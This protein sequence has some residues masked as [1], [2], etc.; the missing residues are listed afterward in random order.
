MTHLQSTYYS[1][2]CLCFYWVCRAVSPLLA[3]GDRVFKLFFWVLI[4]E[5]VAYAL[6]P[7]AIAA[8]RSW[9]FTLFRIMS[10]GGFATLTSNITPLL[11]RMFG[12]RDL[13]AAVAVC[14]WFE[15]LAGTGASVAWIM[16]VSYTG[17][18]TAS[19]SLFFQSCSAIVGV[20][21]I[22]IAGLALVYGQAAQRGPLPL[23][24]HRPTA[25]PTPA[26]G[27]ERRAE[28]V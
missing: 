21:A 17:D 22:V 27:P 11:A 24:T 19:Y 13:H 25:E 28:Q 4:L 20:A 16:H 8:Q 15:P 3:S 5:C 6:T 10:G 2:L 14:S 26:A 18:V 12:M 1:A 7:F 23:R 9:Q